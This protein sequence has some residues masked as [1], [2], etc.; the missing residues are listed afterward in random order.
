VIRD[1]EIDSPAQEDRCQFE[2]LMRELFKVHDLNENGL[3][4]ELELI[5]LN[6]KIAM[7]HYGKDVD[8]ADIT[9]KYR[10]LFRKGLD[11]EGRPVPYAVFRGYMVRVLADIDPDQGAQ[12]MVM[13]QF[14]NEASVARTAFHL[15]SMASVSD[16]PFLA[17][18]QA[19]M[20]GSLRWD[21]GVPDSED[22]EKSSQGEV[23]I[24]RMPS[25]VSGNGAPGASATASESCLLGHLPPPG[26]PVLPQTLSPVP[27]AP[28]DDEAV[29]A[30][31]KPECP[32]DGVAD[33]GDGA[34]PSSPVLQKHLCFSG[35]SPR[36][37]RPG[38]A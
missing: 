15:P 3:L 21:R 29:V 1:C 19:D 28:F 35:M 24:F 2:E 14:I 38:G 33:G 8:L 23:Y 7:L 10:E 13:E 31:S 17:K 36:S 26:R 4:E 30:T 11:P 5:Q 6:K 25:G 22:M 18:M 32:T 12:E 37:V 9:A 34:T 16:L 20:P 27:A